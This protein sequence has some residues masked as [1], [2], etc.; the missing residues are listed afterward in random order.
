MLAIQ[1]LAMTIQNE[2]PGLE[3]RKTELLRTEEELK[4]QLAALEESLLEVGG[5]LLRT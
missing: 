4:V 3:V 1:L 5:L 2:K